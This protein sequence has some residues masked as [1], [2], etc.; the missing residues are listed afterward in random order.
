MQ[1]FA[2]ILGLDAAKNSAAF[3]GIPQRLRSLGLLVAAADAPLISALKSN[4]RDDKA[5]PGHPNRERSTMA[6]QNTELS[7]LADRPAG[8]RDARLALDA[9]ATERRA[10]RRATGS[11]TTAAAIPECGACR[12]VS[13]PHQASGPDGA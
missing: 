4:K 3:V 8:G 11:T 7:A 13:L 6:T 12:V 2:S 10:L 5:R 1:S 9:I